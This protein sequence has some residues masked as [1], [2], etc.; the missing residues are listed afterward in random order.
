MNRSRSVFSAIQR[1][2]VLLLVASSCCTAQQVD[3]AHTLPSNL[4]AYSDGEPEVA[5]RTLQPEFPPSP[6]LYFPLGAFERNPQ[7]STSKENWYSQ[8]L[9]AMDEPSLLAVA[10]A[11]DRRAY[12]FL[13]VLNHRALSF[14]LA[15]N[16][17]GTGNLTTKSVL[18]D[19]KG[20]N[21]HHAKDA[22][23][24]S[25]TQVVEFLALLQKLHFWSAEPEQSVK[26]NRY[27]LDSAE[28]VLEGVSSH[29]YHV[30]DRWAPRDPNF[31]RTGI[32]LMRLAHNNR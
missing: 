22:I 28:W 5:T 11:T 27:R 16:A 29:K 30:V 6:L 20:P 26:E 24:V 8:F 25:E 9:F 3:R 13:L 14:R 7:L 10:K 21:T 19:S 31:I 18:I 4:S 23:P 1:I 12:R 17:D 32:F 15:V 2:A